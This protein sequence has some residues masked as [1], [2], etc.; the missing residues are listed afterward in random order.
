MMAKTECVN[1]AFTSS[2]TAKASGKTS[3]LVSYTILALP[4][5]GELYEIH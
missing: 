4:V 3:A 5:I 2:I 1:T